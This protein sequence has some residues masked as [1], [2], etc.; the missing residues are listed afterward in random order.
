MKIGIITLNGYYNYGNRLQ[1]Y[2]LSQSLLKLATNIQV[3]NIWYGGEGSLLGK[4]FKTA[5]F[6][7]KY[8]LNRHGFR[9]Y[10]NDR[11]YSLDCIREY[12]MK[13]FTDK[14]IPT[15][16]VDNAD[17]E[18]V[19]SQY[20]Y[21]VTG[22]DQIWNPHWIEGKIEFLTFAS[23]EKRIAYAASFG[24]S[25]V[26][27]KKEASFSQYLKDM[28]YISV[29]ENAGAQIV[30]K[31]SGRDVPVVLDPTMLLSRDEWCGI[32]ERPGWYKDENYILIYFLNDLPEAV[33]KSIEMVAEKE[34]LK[35]INVLD[36]ENFDFYTSSPEE[37]L[38]LLEHA[39]LVFTD[40]FHG[41]VFS[42]I[43][44]IPFVNFGRKAGS[45]DMNSRID[46]LLALVELENRRAVEGGKLPDHLF[47][48]DYSVAWE[49]IEKE[50]MKA[51]EF[52]RQALNL[53]GDCND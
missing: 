16:F 2:A 20:D 36:K 47:E 22:S 25:E 32:A 43:M 7:R 26:S 31:L 6:L 52:L 42:I 46:T 23:K 1:N 39:S 45:M 4:K 35:I 51:Q 13:K 37:F 29:R 19:G 9:S 21:F 24:V 49:K 30:K 10:I 5:S 41:T 14:Y 8:F 17:L 11:K 38:F 33:R 18:L 53:A 40:S 34:N 50:K 44:G 48:T 12:N 27:G 28:N 3:D 15:V